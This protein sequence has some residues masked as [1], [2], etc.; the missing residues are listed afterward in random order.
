MTVENACQDLSQNRQCCSERCV[1]LPRKRSCY[2]ARIFDRGKAARLFS[3]EV[4]IRANRSERWIQ[5]F[6]VGIFA[7]A[8]FFT[9]SSHR[10]GGHS[11][12]G[13]MKK[14]LVTNPFEVATTTE[15]GKNKLCFV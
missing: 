1:R 3:S 11:A 5:L 9:E 13:L 6:L 12:A 2:T 4:R 10:I 8:T 7:I 15:S 14:L